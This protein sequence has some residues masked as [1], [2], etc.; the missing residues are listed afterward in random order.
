[1]L[2]S[3]AFEEVLSSPTRTYQEGLLFFR[4]HGMVN[5][6]LRRLAKDLDERGIAYCVIGAVALNQRGY[7]RF[8]EDIDILLTSEGLTRFQNELVGRG[9]RPAFNGA[10]RKFR[11]TEEGVLIKIVV[12]GEFPGDGKPKP[13]A[14][15]D[16]TTISEVIEG[17]RTAS[18]AQLVELKLASGMTGLGRLKDLADVQEMIRVRELD[19]EFAEGL[20]PYV[21]ERYLELWREMVQANSEERERN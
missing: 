2:H 9:Y 7:R 21:R 12:M 19:A 1:M 14:F 15:P 4:G 20:A 10:Q 6:T 11:S 13:V 5:N 8:T 16:P 17:V 18:L 3:T